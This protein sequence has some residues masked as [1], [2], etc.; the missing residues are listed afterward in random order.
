MTDSCFK[1]N[2][3][4]DFWTALEQSLSGL[5]HE[6]TPNDEL[7][8]RDSATASKT[9]RKITKMRQEGEYIKIIKSSPGSK[10][11]GNS[12]IGG[13]NHLNLIQIKGNPVHAWQ[14]QL[15]TDQHS[16]STSVIR[17]LL[18]SLPINKLLTKN[19]HILPSSYV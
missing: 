15:V 12:G 14:P 6:F 19:D 17:P 1:S 5:A 8:P 7:K 4:K 10:T 13:V 16:L 18:N 3:V 9:P 11:S 2:S